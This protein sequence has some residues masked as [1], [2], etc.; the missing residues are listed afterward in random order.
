VDTDSLRSALEAALPGYMVPSHFVLL[1]RLPLTANGKIDRNAL[2][3]ISLPAN[4]STNG[5]EDP[6]GEF[7]QLLANAW[8]ESLGL[9][10]ICR[11]DNFFSLGGHSLAA[12][13]IAFKTQQEFN[14]DFPL[15]MFVQYPILKEQA[16]RLEQMMVE[17]ADA[18]LLESLMA[19]V[20]ENRESSLVSHANLNDATDRLAN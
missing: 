8:A 20:I 6:R 10:R 19:E 2:P 17:Q 4:T 5:G 1:E 9:H 18:G 7:E 15:Q 13:K 16:K 14:V 3:P 11:D 12:L